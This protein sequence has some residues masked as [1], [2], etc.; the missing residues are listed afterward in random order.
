[1]LG[2]DGL[3]R[4][5]SDNSISGQTAHVA[6]NAESPAAIDDLGD[7]IARR[8]LVKG[9]GLGVLGGLAAGALTPTPA[10]ASASES[11]DP[12][13]PLVGCW[14]MD[15]TSNGPLPKAMEVWAAAPGGVLVVHGMLNARVEVGTWQMVDQHTFEYTLVIALFKGQ[16]SY[17]NEPAMDPYHYAGVVIDTGTGRLNS[18]FSQHVTEHDSAVFDACN[19]FVF[20]GHSTGVAT[21]I[22]FGRSPNFPALPFPASI[23]PGATCTS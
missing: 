15:V 14:V 23:H 11:A 20:Q 21:R 5:S 8:R 7:R 9:A 6:I 12:W 2:S 17:P 4:S 18:D 10:S 22:P 13:S 19:N 3:P 1:M 16:Q